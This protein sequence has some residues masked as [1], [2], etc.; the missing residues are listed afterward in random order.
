[1]TLHEI[2]VSVGGSHELD[3]AGLAAIQ[4]QRLYRLI[5]L[6]RAHDHLFKIMAYQN[7]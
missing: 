1:M 3:R 6:L 4:C 2:T 7:L 5:P